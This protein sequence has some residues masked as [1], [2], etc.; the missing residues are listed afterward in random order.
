MG[1][2][3]PDTPVFL[4]SG[5]PRDTTRAIEHL[6][7]LN[8]Q[9]TSPPLIDKAARAM[10][11]DERAEKM[12]P[13]QFVPFYHEVLAQIAVLIPGGKVFFDVYADPGTS[14]EEILRQVH[15]MANWI[16]NGVIGIPISREG[17]KAAESCVKENLLPINLNMCFSQEQAAGAY[18]ATMGAMPGSVYLTIFVDA[19]EKDGKKGVQVM[20]DVMEMLHEG[21]GHLGVLGAGVRTMDQFMYLLGLGPAAV[22][23][24]I[25]ILEEWAEQGLPRPDKKLKYDGRGKTDDREVHLTKDW[26]EYDLSHPLTAKMIERYFECWKS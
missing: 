13:E 25:N 24:P 7:F 17:L 19:L 1:L 15:A 12:T 11:G 6:G 4:E 14:T 8:G 18:R 9:L 5:D 20:E 22:A 10:L 2:Q 26:S 3:V 23:A 16:P 21:D